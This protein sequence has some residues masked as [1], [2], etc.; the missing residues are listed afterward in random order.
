[1]KISHF[2]YYN[3]F[4]HSFLHIDGSNVNFKVKRMSKK[5]LKIKDRGLNGGDLL[6]K[7]V[8]YNPSNNKLKN[9]NTDDYEKFLNVLNALCNDK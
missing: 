1:M 5:V 9:I 8:L 3:G 7:M 2:D 6:I 4:T